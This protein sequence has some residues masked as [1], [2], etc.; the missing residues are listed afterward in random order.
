MD[1]EC[2]RRHAVPAAPRA[3]CD[4]AVETP[5]YGVVF[6]AGLLFLGGSD[7]WL[8]DVA[9]PQVVNR[10]GDRP[11]AHAGVPLNQADEISGRRESRCARALRDRALVARRTLS[12]RH[13]LATGSSAAVL[14][15]ARAALPPA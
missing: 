8:A 14:E 11:A 9:A 2:R 7:K 6:G 4:D 3:G 5:E 15:E 10:I 13:V 12:L 1:A